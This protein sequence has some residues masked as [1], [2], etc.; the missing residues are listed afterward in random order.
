MID[1]NTSVT[2]AEVKELVQLIKKDISKNKGKI[3]LGVFN[4]KIPVLLKFEGDTSGPFRFFEGQEF[5]IHFEDPAGVWRIQINN[6]HDKFLFYIPEEL[7]KLALNNSTPADFISLKRKYMS[8]LAFT[9]KLQ[10][11]RAVTV[12]LNLDLDWLKSRMEE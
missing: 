4:E 8:T 7:K 11:T 12:K 6:S 9:Y 2:N 5:R 10:D 1:K 3:I